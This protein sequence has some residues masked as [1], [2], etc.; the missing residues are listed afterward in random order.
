MVRKSHEPKKQSAMEIRKEVRQRIQ[1]RDT[2]LMKALCMQEAVKSEDRRRDQ[3]ILRRSKMDTKSLPINIQ[4]FIGTLKRSVR[5]TMRYKGGTPFSIV[6]NLFLYWGAGSAA[7]TDGSLNSAQLKQCMDSL[8][9][10]MTDE[11]RAEVVAYYDSG[12]G[13]NEMSYNELLE[14][15]MLGEPT[16]I[17]MSEK[18]Y[19]EGGDIQQRFED[20]DDAFKVMP[21]TVKQFIEAT[22]NYV[23]LAM[24]TEGGTP[25]YH[26]RYLFQFFDYDLSNGLNAQELC[27]AAKKKMKFACTL[28]QA[29][30]IVRYYDRKR[31]GQM[32]YNEFLKDVTAG[33]QPI[34]AFVDITAEQVRATKAALSVNPFMPKPFQAAP[35]KILEQFKQKVKNNLDI[36]VKAHGGRLDSWI[37]EAMMTWDTKCTKKIS[38]WRDLQG[39]AQRLGVSINEEEALCLMRSYD[40]FHTG[41]MHYLDFIQDMMNDDPHFLANVASAPEALPATA[42]MPS[43]VKKTIGRFER[44]LQ[45]FVVKSKGGL[46][47]RDLLYGTCLRFDTSR[48][49]RCNN[50][51]VQKVAKELLGERMSEK[52]TIELIDWFDTNA[53]KTLDYNAFSRQLFRGDDVMTRSLTLPRLSKLAGC[54]SYNFTTTYNLGGGGG[55]GGGVGG[56]KAV[57][58][59]KGPDSE[60]DAFSILSSSLSASASAGALS[61]SVGGGG[62]GQAM[63]VFAGP[64]SLGREGGEG[65]GPAQTVREFLKGEA[66]ESQ[67]ARNARLKQKRDKILHERK[68]VLDKIAQVDAQR[69]KI[70]DDHSNRKNQIQEAKKKEAQDLRLA[71]IIGKNLAAKR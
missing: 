44:A 42:R 69:K 34:L 15:I 10:H 36:K 26:V 58:A 20:V 40:K 8:G 25:Y 18:E 2:S 23:M 66:I 9:V 28:E 50:E 43:R 55:G 63:S 22:Q 61:S 31:E 51:E 5:T 45:A 60:D 29:A 21:K 7:S 16:A 12:K 64:N 54:P 37:K 4:K 32:T 56:G 27:T 19:F 57:A 3:F 47:A 1:E 71:E 53:T 59:Y 65:G 11:E 6:R 35:N 52:D 17:Q 49:G 14:D 38:N 30:E 33:T 70:I 13:T 39:A 41:E 62:R 24:R 48:S 68:A 67:A 46:E